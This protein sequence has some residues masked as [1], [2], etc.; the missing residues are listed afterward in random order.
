MCV[1]KHYY[2]REIKARRRETL[3]WLQAHTS[4]LDTTNKMFTPHH[5]N[6]INNTPS[7]SQLLS[8]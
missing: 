2:E 4:I 5:K 6:K 1:T 7:V 8:L 3:P